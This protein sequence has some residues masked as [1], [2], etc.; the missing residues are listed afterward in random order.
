MRRDTAAARVAGAGRSAGG[1]TF[2]FTADGRRAE[3][4]AVTGAGF[5]ALPL[6]LTAVALSA[7]G[8]TSVPAGGRHPA[9]TA[10]TEPAPPTAGFAFHSRTSPRIA[11][12]PP[13]FRPAF[14]RDRIA[15]AVPELAVVA[16]SPIRPVPGGTTVRVFAAEHRSGGSQPGVGTR[17]TGE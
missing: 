12:G 6:G 4:D 1:G 9:G 16:R 13:I 2:L 8:A 11:A 15:S 10:A 17:R 5:S 3:V 7:Q 14:R